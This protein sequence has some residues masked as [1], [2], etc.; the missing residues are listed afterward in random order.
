MAV[1]HLCHERTTVPTYKTVLAE[2]GHFER[3]KLGQ[4]LRSY[5]QSQMEKIW[6]RL[7]KELL[8]SLHCMLRHTLKTGMF[9]PVLSCVFSER[10]M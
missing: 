10:K 2:V 1:A 5:I 3:R 9:E 6:F 7:V 8:H 4:P